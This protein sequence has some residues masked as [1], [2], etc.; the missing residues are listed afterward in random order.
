MIPAHPSL[1]F[2]KLDQ[3]GDPDLCFDIRYYI[4]LMGSADRRLARMRHTPKADWR[5]EDMKSI[6]RAKT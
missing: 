4:A 3:R 5:I 1:Q 6:A 2:Q